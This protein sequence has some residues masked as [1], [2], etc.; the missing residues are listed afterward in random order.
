MLQLLKRLTPT[1]RQEVLTDLLSRQMQ[2]MDE[3]VRRFME[4]ERLQKM[5]MDAAADAAAEEAAAEGWDTGDDD[6]L[7]NAL[8]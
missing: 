2:L 4:D 3:P 5:A 1:P 7:W 6:G 8:D